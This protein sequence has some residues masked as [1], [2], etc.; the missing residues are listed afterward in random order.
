M[1]TGLFTAMCTDHNVGVGDVRRS[2]RREEPA[3]VRRIYAAEGYH[4][5][6]WLACQPCE[7]DLAVGPADSL[8]QRGRWNRDAGTC[9][10]GAG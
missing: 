2:A 7:P 1:T 8:R 10:T 3:D 5:G 6:R 9:L 4:V